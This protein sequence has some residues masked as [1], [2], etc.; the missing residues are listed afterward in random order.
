MPGLRCGRALR[1]MQAGL[2]PAGHICRGRGAD[3]GRAGEGSRLARARAVRQAHQRLCGLAEALQR[4]ACHQASRRAPHG[5][6]RIQ[7]RLRSVAPIRTSNHTQR[8]Q[9][10]PHACT[11]IESLS[12]SLNW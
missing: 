8:Q 2:L 5:W 6:E 3:T 1:V 9:E 4:R 7:K 12:G 11:E 10:L